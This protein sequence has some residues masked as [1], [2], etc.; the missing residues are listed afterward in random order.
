MKTSLESNNDR[1]TYIN[2]EI[3]AIEDERYRDVVSREGRKKI[4]R[5]K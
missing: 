1:G 5:E 2:R 3:N 4:L